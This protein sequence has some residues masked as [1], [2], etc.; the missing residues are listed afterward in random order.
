MP[1]PSYSNLIEQIVKRLRQ[2]SRLRNVSDDAI[3]A[4]DNLPHNNR[5]PA[6]TVHLESVEE[7]WRSF[8]GAKGG[9]KDALCTVKLTVLDRLPTGHKGYLEGLQNIQDIVRIV[10]DII[11][12]DLGIS[13]TA[14]KSETGTKQFTVGRFDNTPVIGA[15]IQLTTVLGFARAN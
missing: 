2:D 6:I 15:E 4:G 9:L 1:T 3:L 5:W 7:S 8:G 12:S 10:D 14:Y 11:Q 13:G